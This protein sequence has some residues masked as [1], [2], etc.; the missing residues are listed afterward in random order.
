M[1][2]PGAAH[3]VL[4]PI[5]RWT[6]VEHER[7]AEALGGWARWPARRSRW[8]TVN[9]WWS[10]AA[11][12]FAAPL[13]PDVV[14]LDMAPPVQGLTPLNVELVE[15]LLAAVNRHSLSV[16][17]VTGMP[18]NSE[19]LQLAE[20][21]RCFP[22]VTFVLAVRGFGAVKLHPWLQGFQLLEPE[23]I[24][25]ARRAAAQGMPLLVHDSTPPSA[26][27][28]QIG[29]LATRVPEVTVVLADGGLMDLRPDAITAVNRW[30]N[31]MVCLC[32]RASAAMFRQMLDSVPAD[33]VAVGTD[34]G[35]E[36]SGLADHP[37]A[38]LRRFLADRSEADQAAALH[39]N[40][41][42]WFEL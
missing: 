24:E 32:G 31:V 25:I 27:P 9:P 40:A 30:P 18:V 8:V 36:A 10:D 13:G 14:G 3:A 28:L 41:E 23:A 35:F 37:L 19:P 4:G 20:L 34:A 39:A 42:R 15:S 2:R 6:A 21:A 1:D 22:D 16:Y 7:R 11:D 17:V 33:R 26:S 38:V 5:G 12:R 29:E